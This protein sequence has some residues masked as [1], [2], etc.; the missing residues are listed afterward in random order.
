MIPK[1]KL[2]LKS[3]KNYKKLIGKHLDEALALICSNAYQCCV[4]YGDERI[5]SL[6]KDI[7]SLRVDENNIV[8]MAR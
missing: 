4:F 2:A 5:R 6:G 8:T 1:R 7:I 3:S